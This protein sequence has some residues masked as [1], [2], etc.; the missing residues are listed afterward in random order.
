LSIIVDIMTNLSLFV[1][2]KKLNWKRPITTGKLVTE[3]TVFWDVTG[4]SLVPTL[5]SSLLPLS[6]GQ[7]FFYPKNGGNRGSPET[8]VHI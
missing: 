3:H 5:R 7:S 8:A 4:N 1:K 2:T 6:S